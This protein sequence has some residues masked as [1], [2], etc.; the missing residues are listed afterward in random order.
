MSNPTELPDLDKQYA[1][2]CERYDLPAH[3]SR[4]AF[5]DATSLH[6]LR[7]QP[8]REAP[9]AEELVHA[10]WQAERLLRAAGF[11]MTGTTSSQIVAAIAA[12]A[13]AAEHDG[14]QGQ[15]K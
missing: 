2:W 6:L 8:E 13:A 14:D 3:Q 15:G 9:Q 1:E 7:A 5:D 4:E 11:A 10:L 12:H